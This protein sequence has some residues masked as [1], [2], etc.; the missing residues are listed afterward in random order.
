MAIQ[1]I[2]IPR[3][4]LWHRYGTLWKTFLEALGFEVVLSPRTD[5]SIFELGRAYSTDEVCL[6]SQTY[7][8]HV[9]SL[10]GK[11]DAVLVPCFESRN[12]RAGF[13]TKYQSLPDMVRATFKDESVEF[14]TLSVP[15]ASDKKHASRAYIDFAATKLGAPVSQ[16]VRAWKA[17]QKAQASLDK[18]R[19]QAQEQAFKLLEKA[20]KRGGDVPL[21][22]LLAAHPYVAHDD[23]II[24]DIV[25]CLRELG[26]V[27]LYADETNAAAT[28]KK[29][30]EASDTLPWLINRELLGS[31]M[32]NKNKVDGVILVS[33]FPCGPDSMFDDLVLRTVHD[34]PILNLIID[35]Q[36]GTA[37]IQTRLESF[38]DILGFQKKGSYLG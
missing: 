21:S 2:G 1:T 18:E 20:R 24:G 27:V 22:V 13:C 29:S 35:A 25:N 30:F 31:I 32:L 16:A 17:A 12:V 28:F 36:S 23:Y 37:G 3:G 7:L 33:A 15:D 26:V 10:V 19:A 11:C 8:G 6:A 34:V 14:I 38:V 5:R 9:A 4:L